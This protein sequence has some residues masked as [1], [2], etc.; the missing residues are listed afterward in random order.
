MK[1]TDKPNKEWSSRVVT[2]ELDGGFHRLRARVAQKDPRILFE[3]RD[4]GQLFAQAN[5]LLMV[6]I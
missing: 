4:L 6:I 2:G 5:P 1:A 3:R